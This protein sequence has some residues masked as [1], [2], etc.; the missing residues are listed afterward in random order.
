MVGAASNKSQNELQF[1]CFQDE[2][3]TVAN[4]LTLKINQVVSQ[5]LTSEKS[6]ELCVF[7]AYP[8]VEETHRRSHL[9]ISKIPEIEE[10]KDQ[11]TRELKNEEFSRVE[12]DQKINQVS[13]YAKKNLLLASNFDSV[14]G[15]DPEKATKTS[16]Y[17]D[18]RHWEKLPFDLVQADPHE[19]RVAVSNGKDVHIFDPI[20]MK[21]SMVISGAHTSGITDLDF[22]P[23]KRHCILTASLDHT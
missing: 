16:S 3:N 18:K 4:L 12:F 6:K 21:Q 15:V 7:T 20:S 1:I 14:V 23:N 19:P 10:S 2:T 17:N 9:F 5:V 13:F 22:N 8:T 11:E